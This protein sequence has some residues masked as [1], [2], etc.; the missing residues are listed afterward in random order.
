MRSGPVLGELQV[1]RQGQVQG[2]GD[3]G[4][5]G[6]ELLARDR[7][8]P[9]GQGQGAGTL[10]RQADAES[11]AGQAA[12]G[13]EVEAGEGQGVARAQQEA[14]PGQG[15]GGQAPTRVT[16]G[17][18]RRQD[19]QPGLGRRLD[20]RGQAQV[21]LVARDLPQQ[22]EGAGLG[23]VHGPPHR[24]V[25]EGHALAD[26]PG[27]GVEE[28]RQDA[29]GPGGPGTVEA[30][31]GQGLPGLGTDLELQGE[32]TLTVLQGLQAGRRDVAGRQG[33]GSRGRRIA[34][35][36]GAAQGQ[37]QGPEQGPSA[38]LRRNLIHPLGSLPG[39]GGRIATGTSQAASSRRRTKISAAAPESS[40]L[41]A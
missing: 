21:Q 36:T 25:P 15:P 24:V 17:P 20:A 8:A 1:R 6:R 40:E 11:L 28:D 26:E 4:R 34:G 9:Q 13:G 2:L 5:A 29:A 14:V 22:G 7:L 30:G 16:G 23:E 32:G 31:G 35:P 37:A 39:P 38:E 18:G 27:R 12:P 3:V 10:G 33:L 19:P 41:T